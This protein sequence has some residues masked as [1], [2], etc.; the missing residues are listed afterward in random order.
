MALFLLSASTAATIANAQV[1]APPSPPTREEIERVPT[2]PT[3][4]PPSRLRVE[5]GIERAPCP[6]ADPQYQNVTV[7]IS[8]VR[9]DN[10]KVV[11]PDLLRP[12]WADYAGK[13]VPIAAV[14]EIRDAAATILRREGYLAAVQVP[15]QRI[16][17]GV[18]R[19][20]VLMAK[21]V[22]VQVRGDAGKSEKL[23]AGY[24][25]KLTS[26]EVFN[27]KYAERYLLLARDIPGFDVRLT[28]RPAGTVPGEVIG[29]VTVVRVP[30][31]VDANVQNFGSRSVG[32][33]GGLVR[34][35]FYDVLGLGDR[36]VAGAYTTAQTSEQNVVQLGYDMRLGSDGLVLAGRFAYAW[37]TPDI[38]PIDPLESHTMVASIEASYP[39]LRSQAT[40]IR[41]A[42]GL[43][44]IDQDVFFSR[45]INSQDHLRVLYGRIDFEAIDRDSISSTEGYSIGEPRWRIAG[46]YEF[47]K[48]LDIFDASED[49][50]GLGACTGVTRSRPQGEATAGLIRVSG[51]AEYRPSPRFVLALSPRAQYTRRPLLSYEEFSG[52]TYTIG[53]GYDP[54][55]IIGD[56]GVGFLAEVRVGSLSPQ[57]REGFAFQ[58]YAF[59]DQAWTWEKD[60]PIALDPANSEKLTSAGVGVRAAYGDHA[61]IDVALAKPLKRLAGETEKG[62]VRLL[63][64]LTTKLIPW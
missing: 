24:L 6:L 12:A 55:S 17:N 16:E 49:C 27:E 26:Q 18:V 40:N 58:P 48:G 34:G 57:S 4:P 3:T 42:A 13:T 45:V 62:D 33:W 37:T 2:A 28:M 15:P 52:G 9:F 14:C 60:R 5:G 35:E 29:E 64:S 63:F 41:A 61:R 23:I 39:F 56:T 8:D 30:F 25:N 21:L 50:P 53:R 47:R 22:G 7:A 36:L 32:R 46:T 43:D 1:A 31:T 54:G 38:G 19:F 11:S 59:L 10:L 51:T 44:W 20:D